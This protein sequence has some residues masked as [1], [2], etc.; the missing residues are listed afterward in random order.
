MTAT[1]R[2]IALADRVLTSCL[3]HPPSATTLSAVAYEIAGAFERGRR[4][5]RENA[6][7]SQFAA[8]DAYAAASVAAVTGA[9]GLMTA[10][11]VAAVAA[12]IAD[13]LIELRNE[14][15]AKHED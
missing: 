3:G 4:H 12:E 1:D 13:A 5:E 8:W 7:A 9:G 11:D 6:R 10:F 2:D 15:T 14:R